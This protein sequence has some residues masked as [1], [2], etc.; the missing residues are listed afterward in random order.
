MKMK[1]M[2]IAHRPMAARRFRVAWKTPRYLAAEPVGEGMS[3][4][5]LGNSGAAD[6]DMVLS[7]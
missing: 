1:V 7:W 6:I 5:Q 2:A 4:A 3:L